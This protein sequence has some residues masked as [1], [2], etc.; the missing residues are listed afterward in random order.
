MLTLSQ[1]SLRV[2]LTEHELRKALKAK[3]FAE[4][5]RLGRC[6]GFAEQDV[7]VIRQRL[8]EAGILK[9]EEGRITP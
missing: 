8:V 9:P 2:Q 4:S 1:L 6:R 7:P 3:L 5:V